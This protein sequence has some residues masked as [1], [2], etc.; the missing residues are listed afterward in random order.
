MN[1]LVWSLITLVLW[2]LLGIVTK[3]TAAFLDWKEYFV[4]SFL[5]G[6]AITSIVYLYFRPEITLQKTGFQYALLAGVMGASAVVS[7][8]LAL[9]QGSAAIV[10]PLTALYPLITILLSLL[11]LHERIT[12][13]QGIGIVLALISIFLMSL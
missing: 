2:G 4:T 1:W 12:L 3:I 13:I 7:F 5:G 9:R 10:I 11:V 6:L 8:Y